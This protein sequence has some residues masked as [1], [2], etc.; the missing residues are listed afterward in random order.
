M[1]MKTSS[2]QNATTLLQ[3]HQYEITVFD[4][5]YAQS[6]SNTEFCKLVP[7]GV[8]AEEIEPSPFC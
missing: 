2:T 6:Q 8:N 1:A 7:S 5:L 4:R 3:M